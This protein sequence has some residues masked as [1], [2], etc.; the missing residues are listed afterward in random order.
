MT[1][2]E[3]DTV[4]G[5]VRAYYQTQTTNS[6]QGYFENFMG[7][8]GTLV[9]SES[10]AGYK[11]SLYRQPDAPPWD[12]W[13]RKGYVSAP[14]VQLRK[15]EIDLST[16]LD[17]RETVSPDKHMI[18]IDFYDPYHK[19][20]LENFFNTIRGTEEL[21]CPPQIGYETAVTVLKV[22]EAIE[23]RNRLEYSPEEFE[24]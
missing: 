4:E 11:G 18:P 5:K 17:V 15:Q 3:Y 13:V 7:D 10:E 21:N 2:F 9:V 12:E 6:S 16:M 20:H 1:I 14:E 23:K 19:P 8:Q 22:N 24:I